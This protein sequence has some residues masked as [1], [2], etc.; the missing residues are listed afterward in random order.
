M[1]NPNTKQK[2]LLTL[3]P[4]VGGVA[5]VNSVGSPILAT[6]LLSNVQWQV[7]DPNTASIVAIDATNVYIVPKQA[8]V[9]TVIVTAL[10]AAGHQLTDQITITFDEFIPNA[11]AL[12]LTEVSVVDQ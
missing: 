8:G 6:A 10:N 2:V 1:A 5:P 9:V 3:R 4:T 12:G 7:T 11:D